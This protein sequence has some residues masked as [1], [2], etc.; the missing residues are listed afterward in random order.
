MVAETGVF[1]QARY[2]PS[3]YSSCDALSCVFRHLPSTQLD[4][5]ASCKMLS[6]KFIHSSISSSS[7]MDTDCLGAGNSDTFVLNEGL[8]RTI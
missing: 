3:D 7:V 8:R 2:C 5:A 6:T 1:V 4:F